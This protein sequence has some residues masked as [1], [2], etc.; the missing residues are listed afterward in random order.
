MYSKSRSEVELKGGCAVF[1]VERHVVL[2]SEY[3][4]LKKTSTFFH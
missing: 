4:I 1:N 2:N 3:K